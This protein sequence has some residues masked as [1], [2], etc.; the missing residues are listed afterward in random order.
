MSPQGR[1]AKAGA[2]PWVTTAKSQGLWL[3]ECPGRGAGRGGKQS[4]L[5]RS[6]CISCGFL[7]GEPAVSLSGSKRK[8]RGV[9]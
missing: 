6:M 5:G 2:R 3:A 4:E 9:E 7:G 1:C 8:P